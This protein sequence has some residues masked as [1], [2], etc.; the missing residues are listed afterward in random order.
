VEQH[1]AP[2]RFRRSPSIDPTC[3]A[4][5]TERNLLY[6][7]DGT[8]L[9]LEIDPSTFQVVGTL[10]RMGEAG[11]MVYLPASQQ[12]W[13]ESSGSVIAFDPDSDRALADFPVAT[14]SVNNPYVASPVLA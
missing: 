14:A 4:Y 5:D 9:I 11:P 10:D 8:D 7:S 2:G 12:L 1:G 3:A 13:I 6:V